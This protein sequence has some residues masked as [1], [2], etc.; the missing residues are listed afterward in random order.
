MRVGRRHGQVRPQRLGEVQL[1]AGADPY[2]RVSCRPRPFAVMALVVD[3][4]RSDTLVHPPPE[5]AWRDQ[6]LDSTTRWM[7]S[8][9]EG[10]AVGGRRP[11]GLAAVGPCHVEAVGLANRAHEHHLQHGRIHS[12]APRLTAALPCAS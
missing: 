3:D 8:W 4:L 11:T 5:A 1:G 9:G 2:G 6:R 7:R 12:V 10:V